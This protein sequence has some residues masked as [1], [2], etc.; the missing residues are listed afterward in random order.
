MYMVNHSTRENAQSKVKEFY[1]KI[2]EA[3]DIPAPL[4]IASASPKLFERHA[5][6]LE[7]FAGHE[8]L[9]PHMLAAIRYIVSS[10]KGFQPCI[11]FN[12]GLL[13]AMG[14]ESDDVRSLNN[15][16]IDSA[17]EKKELMLLEF[18]KDSIE[19]PKA[20]N[21]KDLEDLKAEGWTEQDLVD[22]VYHA[23]AMF[24]AGNLSGTFTE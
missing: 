23:S 1:D 16:P 7:Y 15:S 19:N 9:E 18:V 11:D 24:I 8:T 21:R 6:I 12:S 22:A 5:N 2:P 4:L 10:L 14:M 17:F 20:V 13:T 3:F